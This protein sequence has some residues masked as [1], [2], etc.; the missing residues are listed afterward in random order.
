VIGK[1]RHGPDRPVGL[2]VLKNAGTPRQKGGKVR[3]CT[4][5]GREGR[6]RVL[7][8]MERRV[9]SVKTIVLI[10]S[11]C[12]RTGGRKGKKVHLYGNGK[13]GNRKLFSVPWAEKSQVKSWAFLHSCM[14]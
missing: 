1:G 11:N 4:C 6:K 7:A 3:R 9:I 14:A 12:S 8:G 5:T 10:K 13:K 2:H